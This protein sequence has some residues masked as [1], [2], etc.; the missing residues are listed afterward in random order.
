V[1]YRPGYRAPRRRA[2]SLVAAREAFGEH[3]RDMTQQRSRKLDGAQLLPLVRA[4]V[5][6]VDG[7]RQEQDAQK[8]A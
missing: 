5:R 7:V 8:A 1:R 4:G 6:F 3:F 2:Q